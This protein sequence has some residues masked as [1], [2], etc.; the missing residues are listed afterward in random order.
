MR[1]LDSLFYPVIYILNRA[2]FMRF[3]RL[4]LMFAY[5]INGMGIAWPSNNGLSVNETKFFKRKANV[6]DGGTVFDIGANVGSYAHAV[7]SF[8]PNS[9]IICFEPQPKTFRLLEANCPDFVLERLAL[10]DRTGSAVLHEVEGAEISTVA[11]LSAA[12]LVT[13]GGAGE[14]FEVALETVD[15]YCEREGIDAIRLMK[16]DTEGHDLDVLRGASAMLAREA[17]DL[18][19]FEFIPANIYTGAHFYEFVKILDGYELYRLCLNGSLERLLPYDWRFTELYMIYNVI[20][21]R[22]GFQ[23]GG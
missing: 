15:I 16:I 13:H 4:V 17:I 6:I 10:A 19:E 18:I 5:R 1:W 11:S 12:T 21:I 3:N 22:R 2:A 20:A 8:C 9:P 14:S 23:V 7:R